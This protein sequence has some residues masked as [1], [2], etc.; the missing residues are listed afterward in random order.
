[1]VDPSHT[2]Q[3]VRVP[4]MRSRY[5]VTSLKGD[6][7]KDSRKL[8]HE[9]RVTYDFRGTPVLRLAEQRDRSGGVE[10]TVAPLEKYR[11]TKEANKIFFDEMARAGS[12]E[13][14][15]RVSHKYHNGGG[16]WAP[17]KDDQ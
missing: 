6:K 16:S 8:Q 17:P 4:K 14:R 10:E 12:L 1:M 11:R 2:F 9:R 7:E 15:M 13:E 3:D 5:N